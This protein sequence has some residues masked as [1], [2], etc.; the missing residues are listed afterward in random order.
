[1]KNTIVGAKLLSIQAGLPKTIHDEKTLDS[2]D[3]SWTT[4]FF[5]LPV[6]GRIRLNRTNLD[7]DGQADLHNHGGIEKAIN[8]YPHEHYGFW[9]ERLGIQNLEHGAFG[10]N[11]TI[12]GLTE[13]DVC[14]GDVFEIG[15]V[16]VQISQP[17][18]PCWK[19]SRRWH[20]R[21]LALQVQNSGRT[22]WYFRVLTEGFVEADLPLILAERP[23]P[24]WTVAL[25]NDIMHHHTSD[26]EA[27]RSLMECHFLA[28]R[29]RSTLA[30]RLE[31]G[32]ASNNAARLY[33]PDL[34]SQ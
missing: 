24:Q 18:Q 12:G 11:F 26:M 25:A 7:G 20:V 28:T 29:W 6:Y 21:D 15:E 5:K 23:Y 8:A 19:L 34:S 3:R 32:V 2:I 1:M 10:E 22:G 27:A 9:A 31:T 17:R 4:G 16:R 33:G 13:S 30:K 14:I